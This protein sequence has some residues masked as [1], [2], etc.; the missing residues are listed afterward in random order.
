MGRGS[1]KRVQALHDLA[2]EVS[3]YS[4][5]TNRE[6]MAYLARGAVIWSFV[7]HNHYGSAWRCLSAFICI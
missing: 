1:I 3:C 2:F 4:A 6:A 7:E 5:R